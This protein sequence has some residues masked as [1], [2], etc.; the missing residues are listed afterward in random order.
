MK[1]LL[2]KT[3]LDLKKIDKEGG[4]ILIPAI[5]TTKFTTNVQLVQLLLDKGADANKEGNYIYIGKNWT[6][7]YSI[8]IIST[9]KFSLKLTKILKKKGAKID[10]E[11]NGGWTALMF[12]ANS[13]HFKVVKYLV[14]KGADITGLINKNGKTKR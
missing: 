9:A 14:S 11:N 8:P 3:S 12:A 10:A 7:T 1:F 6:N 2:D 4:N 13:G 5:W